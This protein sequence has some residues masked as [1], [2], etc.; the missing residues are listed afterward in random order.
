MW[1]QFP[2][3]GQL[4]PDGEIYG[5]TWPLYFL[6]ASGHLRRGCLPITYHD[7]DVEDPQFLLCRLGLGLICGVKAGQV[8]G[9]VLVVDVEEQRAILQPLLPPAH[10]WDVIRVARDLCK[11]KAGHTGNV[12]E[13]GDG[14]RSPLPP[15]WVK[16]LR[17]TH[18]RLPSVTSC[19]HHY[20]PT[21]PTAQRVKVE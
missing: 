9:P 12:E 3:L 21:Q 5:N 14:G 2:V 15:K 17:D 13:R 6:Q 4:D 7:R 8:G 1:A 16:G 19:Q 11:S 18:S 20:C 10:Q